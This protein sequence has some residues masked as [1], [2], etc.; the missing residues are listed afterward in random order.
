MPITFSPH[1]TCKGLSL[2]LPTRLHGMTGFRVE[3]TVPSIPSRTWLE[4]LRFH[5]A[6]VVSPGCAAKW[7]WPECIMDALRERPRSYLPLFNA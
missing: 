5:T 7:F 2:L 1:A 4:A 6:P 3:S